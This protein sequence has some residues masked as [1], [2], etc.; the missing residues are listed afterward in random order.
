MTNDNNVP[1][2]TIDGPGGSGK[3]TVSSLLAD[4]LGFNLLDSGAIYRLHAYK[5]A[6]K[7]V[8]LDDEAGLVKIAENLNIDFKRLDLTGQDQSASVHN[9]PV[10]AFLDGIDVSANIRTEKAGE[11]ASKSS[12]YQKV[13]DCLLKKQQSFALPPGLV[14]DGRDMGSVVFPQAQVKIYLD[15]SCAVRAKR[16][17]KQ[18]QQAGVDV[19]FADLLEEVMARDQRDKMRSVSPLVVPKGAV[20]VNTDDLNAQEVFGKILTLINRQMNLG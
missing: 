10:S 3:G 9:A 13:R 8:A 12:K 2:I 7:N 6:E 14:A 17:H 15:A 1:I 5:A 11:A 16:R 4:R 19:R 20:I 18:L